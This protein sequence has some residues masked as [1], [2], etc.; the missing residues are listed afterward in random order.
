MLL[1]NGTVVAAS[2]SQALGTIVLK[3]HFMQKKIFL[4]NSEYEIGNWNKY[5]NGYKQAS[6]I[7]LK[8]YEE[9]NDR[10]LDELLAFPI[11]FLFRHFVELQLKE[12]LK[13]YSK[14]YKISLQKSTI[15]S[16][17]DLWNEVHPIINNLFFESNGIK[18]ENRTNLT[19]KDV[20]KL[21]R[22]IR[23][24]NNLDKKSEAFRY[25]IDTKNR[26]SITKDYEFSVDELKS[27]ILTTSQ[28]LSFIS[29]I[30]FLT[31]FDKIKKNNSA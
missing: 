16:L 7:L 22:T 23:K 24:L 11:F 12:I 17:I 5:A 1:I 9:S 6:I 20:N 28:L 3:R 19:K 29:A 14:Y 18:L 10:K 13:S 8:K 4:W 31:N 30:R 26:N 21:G 25:P 2:A 15:H 27:E